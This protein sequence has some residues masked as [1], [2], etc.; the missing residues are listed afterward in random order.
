M[1]CSTQSNV[2]QM[3]IPST[4][5]TTSRYEFFRHFSRSAVTLWNYF[6]EPIKVD[7]IKCLV[8]KTLNLEPLLTGKSV[9]IPYLISTI[10]CLNFPHF[11]LF[12]HEH[13][14]F[15]MKILA[16]FDFPSFASQ[17]PMN[18]GFRQVPKG[19]YWKK[20]AATKTWSVVHA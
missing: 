2:D 9:V 14:I 5:D 19:Q 6:V 11:H 1:R 7:G 3:I 16:Y 13:C 10:A 20:M 8:Q 17:T 15:C 18:L 12:L 4:P